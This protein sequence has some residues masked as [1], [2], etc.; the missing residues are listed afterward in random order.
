MSMN[1]TQFGGID[2]ND[3]KAQQMRL[4]FQQMQQ[5]TQQEQLQPQFIY[6]QQ[7]QQL[8]FQAQYFQY[9]LANGLNATDPNVYNNYCMVMNQ[10]NMAGSQNFGQAMNNFNNMGNNMGN[11][12][13]NMNIFNNTN[14][15]VNN[16][17]NN[18]QNV[19]EPY[20][21]ESKDGQPKEVIP[22]GDK[23]IFIKKN[24]F[25]GANI[26]NQNFNPMN[27]LAGMGGGNNIINITFV[28][29]SGLNV[30]IPA[31]KTMTF[32]GLF[33]AYAKK[34]SIPFDA[35]EKEI[36]FLYNAEKIDTKSQRPISTLFK[37]FTAF[38]YVR[39]VGL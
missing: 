3:P 8:E 21:Q 11:N 4:V 34:V 39:T 10:N 6:Q 29:T 27:N 37:S 13:P 23:T 1:N 26:P 36:F 25:S 35:F 28:A 20:V 9:C 5:K 2:F 32:E 22:R 7:Q 18:T 12:M 31:P 15:N 24:D 17:S 30:V 33:K 38:I 19:N 14:N 16:Q